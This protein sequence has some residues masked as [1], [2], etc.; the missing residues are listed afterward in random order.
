MMHSATEATTQDAR[1]SIEEECNIKWEP[2]GQSLLQ[3]A[4]DLTTHTGVGS[5]SH[6]AARQNTGFG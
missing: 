4:L 5:A 6:I 3:I 2:G 1:L